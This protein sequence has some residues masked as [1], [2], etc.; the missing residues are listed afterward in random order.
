MIGN[1]DESSNI[2]ESRL[3]FTKSLQLS[4]AV[5]LLLTFIFGSNGCAYFN[6]FYMAKKFYSDAEAEQARAKSE[7]LSPQA[8]SKYDQSIEKC[9]KVIV[10]HGGG[11]RAGID[12]ALFLMGACYYGKREYETAIKKFNELVL[13]YPDSDHI[14]DAMFYSGMCY[15]KLRNSATAER[16][17]ARVLKDKPNYHRRDE[18]ILAAA[19]A[20]ERNGDVA[21]AA[22]QYNLLVDQFKDSAK[23]HIA[24]DHLGKIYFNEGEF[25]SSLTAYE[26]LARQTQDDELYF[27]S[28]LNVGANLVRLRRYDEAIEIYEKILPDNPDRNENGGRVKLAIAETYNRSGEHEKAIEYLTAVSEGFPNRNLGLEA[29]FRLGYT[30]EVYL[31]NYTAAREAYEQATRANQRSVFKDQAQRRLINV[32]RLEEISANSTEDNEPDLLN[33]DENAMAALQVAEFTYF[34]SDDLP[35]ALSQYKDVIDGYPGSEPAARA[36]FARGWI[37]MSELD[38]LALSSSEFE[39]VAETYPASDQA[40]K[41]LLFV[42]E[43]GLVTEERRNQLASLVYEALAVEQARLDSLRADSVATAGFIADSIAAAKVV[44]DS[45]AALNPPESSGQAFVSVP[46][47]DSLQIP[48]DSLGA[49]PSPLDALRTSEDGWRRGVSVLGSDSLPQLPDSILSPDPVEIELTPDEQRALARR[50]AEQLR[51]TEAQSTQHPPSILAPQPSITRPLVVGDSLTTVSDSLAAPIDSLTR[52][53]DSL[54]IMAQPLV[55]DSLDI[56]SLPQEPDSLPE[57][58]S[59]GIE[60]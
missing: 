24:L 17:F 19:D 48:T 53:A 21:R 58:G 1:R 12:D 32:K 55:P 7:K 37:Y 29:D 30:H 44:A 10:E 9:V 40:E 2:P 18:I 15:Y 41:S 33:S 8:D 39:Y 31:K 56:E 11:W 49:A 16:I 36:A 43:I 45:I 54:G 28:Q 42:E 25:D 38:S 52:V 4:A 51:Q 6:T 47:S 22:Q 27:E 35:L 50:E 34:E 20:F 3:R 59:L 23:R 14:H 5:I 46:P 60:G 26:E 57:T 13:N